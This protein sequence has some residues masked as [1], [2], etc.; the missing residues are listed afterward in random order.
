MFDKDYERIYSETYSFTRADFVK[1][2]KELEE[3]NEEHR[4]LNGELE[5]EV[6]ELTRLVTNK[7][8]ADYDYDS[9]LKQELNEERGRNIVLSESKNMIET[10]IKQEKQQ[11]I[12]FLEEKIKENK[13]NLL[14]LKYN[15]GTT[16]EEIGEY[17]G[18]LHSYQEALDFV[19]GGKN[20]NNT[21]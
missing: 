3:I 2:I 8:L 20:E 15:I 4:K 19:K 7:V 13:L 14:N 11:L 6:K 21:I 16:Y 10:E 12:S 9:I 18:S 5:T 17:K 1:R